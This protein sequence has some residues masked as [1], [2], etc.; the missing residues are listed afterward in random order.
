[1]RIDVQEMYVC[2]AKINYQDDPL[3]SEFKAFDEVDFEEIPCAICSYDEEKDIYTCITGD[4]SGFLPY[5]MGSTTG[6]I[7]IYKIIEVR[8]PS[9][10]KVLAE[11][12]PLSDELA[13]LVAKMAMR[14]G[15][16]N[17]IH[18]LKNKM[19]YSYISFYL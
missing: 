9:L 12:S 5:I 18:Y 2:R 1:M 3:P 11:N 17:Y 13:K 19:I 7:K 8:N 6:Q 14:G 15:N 10:N 16:K 4:K